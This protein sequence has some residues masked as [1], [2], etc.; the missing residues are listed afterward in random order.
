VP[1][2]ATVLH[3][4]HITG[5]FRVDRLSSTEAR[6]AGGHA[7]SFGAELVVVFQ[8]AEL[9]PLPVRGH[10]TWLCAEPIG[11]EVTLRCPSLAALRLLEFVDALAALER[12]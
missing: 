6:L 5:P 7:L 12:E 2:T 1:V 10:V 8:H 3:H 9:G 11:V 4:G